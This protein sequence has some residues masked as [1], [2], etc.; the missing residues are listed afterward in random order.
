M[1]RILTLGTLSIITSLAL[2]SCGGSSVSNLVEEAVANSTET[3]KGYFIDAAVE[4]LE[5]KATPSGKS[6]TTDANGTFEY[7]QGDKVKFHLAHLDL[8]EGTP[9]ED[10]L[11]TPEQLLENEALTQTKKEDKK[12][13]MLRLLQSLDSDNNL[14]NGISIDEEVLQ[15]LKNGDLNTTEFINLDEEELLNIHQKMQNKIDKDGDGIM[16]VDIES[17]TTHF[18]QSKESWQKGERPNNSGEKSNDLNKTIVEELVIS[19]DCDYPLSGVVEYS[20]ANGTVVKS[21]DY[22]NGVCDSLINVTEDGNT[23]QVDLTQK[24]EMDGEERPSKK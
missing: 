15:S 3:L 18:E 12:V 8:G 5:Y 1:K 10:G 21:V 16:D 24:S 4:G 2:V 20:D 7:Q 22:G 11:M 23:T 17:A 6:G 19:D 14:S 13:L 9:D